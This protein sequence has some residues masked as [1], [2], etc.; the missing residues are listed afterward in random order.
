M[1][2][3][4]SMAAVLQRCA[5]PVVLPDAPAVPPTESMAR[6]T[7]VHHAIDRWVETRRVELT[8]DDEVDAHV[9]TFVRDMGPEI[10]VTAVSEVAFAHN[11]HT[12]EARELGRGLQRD[13]SAAPAG[14]VCGTADGVWMD[15][16]TVVV[17]EV[18]TGW[19]P[20]G[21]AEDHAQLATLC[22]MAARAYGVESARGILVHVREDSCRVT[23]A[24]LDTLA[25]DGH[26]MDMARWV[27]GDGSR[28]PRPGDHCARCPGRTVCPAVTQALAE[29][30]RWD[31]V[32]AEDVA[33]VWHLLGP[34]EDKIAAIKR[35]AREL[36]EHEPIPLPSGKR[37]K[38]VSRNG[39]ESVSVSAI[40]SGIADELRAIGALKRGAPYQVLTEVKGT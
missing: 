11:P 38:L 22:T 8:G 2:V 17:L 5:H 9:A 27:D 16:S 40:P 21:D 36:A 10:P 12:G 34:I 25:L 24:R 33:R 14:W 19:E 23:M 15:G 32:T 28:A 31:V 18:K 39:R 4:A 30:S 7:R 6:G 1:R 13:Y 29:S 26:E 20:H 3:T 37:L 35:V